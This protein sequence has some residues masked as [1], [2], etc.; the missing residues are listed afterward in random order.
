MIVPP[1]LAGLGRRICRSNHPDHSDDRCAKD[2][3]AET[4]GE[5]KPKREI[6][7]NVTKCRVEVIWV[8]NSYFPSK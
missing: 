5:I 6:A 4:V 1:L 7:H 2:H 3:K 8:V